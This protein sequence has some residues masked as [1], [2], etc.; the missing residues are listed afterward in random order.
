MSK[1]K[2][3]LI[4]ALALL[5]TCSSV[6]A[7]DLYKDMHR[8]SSTPAPQANV[9]EGENPEE[10]DP[11]ALYRPK[12]AK[13]FYSFVP[14]AELYVPS[15]DSNSGYYPYPTMKSAIAKYKRGNYSGCLQELYAYIKKHPGDA[16]A[17]YYMGLSYVRVGRNDVAQK[18]FQKTIN[19][20]A[21]GK[22]LE[23]AVK[24]RDCLSGGPYCH[25]PINPPNPEMPVT[26][27]SQDDPAL[28]AFVNAPYS[29]H[30]FSPE[31]EQQYRQQKLNNMQKTIN[32]KE[33]L[34]RDDIEEI[35]NIEKKNLR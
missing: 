29:G 18:C 28:D 32:R 30:G 7:Y 15:I 8:S 12:T 33:K 20:N 3:I 27:P 13:D 24:G 19:C 14:I 10:Q 17:F 35:K 26:D 22:L 4:T 6:M 1:E 11:A 5:T 23:M 21:S 2:A 9:T 34:D 31:L 25:E 16:Y